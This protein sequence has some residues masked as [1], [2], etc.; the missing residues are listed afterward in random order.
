MNNFDEEI[1]ECD[2]CQ[3]TGEIE[4]C[5]EDEYIVNV[6]PFCGGDGY[7]YDE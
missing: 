1:P 4:T 2:D 5:I 3:G 7:I 6:C